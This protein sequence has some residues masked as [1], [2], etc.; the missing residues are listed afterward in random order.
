MTDN[1]TTV[2]QKLDALGI[3]Y[4]R[5]DHQPITTV[6]EGKLIA[7]QLGSV[8]CKTLLLKGKRGYWLLMLP[9]DK[10]LVNKALAAQIGSGHLSFGSAEELAELLHTF[11]G[12]VSVLG[13]IFDTEHRVQLLID[14]DILAASHIDCHPCTNDCSVKMAVSDIVNRLLPAIGHDFITVTLE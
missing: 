2:F 6:A 12:A 7:E 3:G 10:K 1:T 9:A 4:L 13:L 14:A 8:C 5:H 11:P